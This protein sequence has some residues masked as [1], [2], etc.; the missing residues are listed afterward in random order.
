[1]KP[2]QIQRRAPY[3]I[4]CF[5]AAA[6]IL[7]HAALWNIS[8]I[9]EKEDIHYIFLDGSRLVDGVNPYE[10]VLSGDMRRNR[11][12][13]TYLPLFYL[14]SSGT[15]LL[16]LKTFPEWLA[17]WRVIFLVCNIGVSYLILKICI[18]KGQ[19]LLGIFGIIFWMFNRWTLHVTAI[20]HIDFIPLFILMIS[21]TILPRRFYLAC[22][23]F[24]LSLAIKQIAIFALP[25]YLIWSLRTNRQNKLK[26]TLVTLVL[27]TAI[28]LLV[29]APFLIWNSEGYLKSI[30]FSA[31]RFPDGHFGAPSFDA[32]AGFY[33]LP[34]KIPMLILL[35]LSYT[36]VLIYRVPLHTS[37]F[38]I[39]TVFICFNSV[40]FRQ[41]IIWC[42]PFIPLAIGE[43][44]FFQRG[45][46]RKQDS[47]H[48][49]SKRHA[50]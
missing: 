34:A 21:L 31:T 7:S 41:Y 42:L 45:T 36:L 5:V 26:H 2:L 46:A 1:M 50:A 3:V 29:S 25:V 37:H 16:G 40:L 4:F 15:Q 30:L 10:R 18:S 12:Y 20:S 43:I 49:T 17:F 19:V 47:V 14:L 33:G 22:L 38:L 39:M 13:T 48:I 35:V 23:L 9:M 8:E 27:I 44:S 6:G 11:K 24:G 32:L 28:P